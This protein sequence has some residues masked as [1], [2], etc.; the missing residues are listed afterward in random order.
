MEWYIIDFKLLNQVEKELTWLTNIAV[1]FAVWQL[2]QCF[3][4]TFIF[5]QLNKQL[6]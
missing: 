1:V 2:K 6:L 3:I 4:I 5:D